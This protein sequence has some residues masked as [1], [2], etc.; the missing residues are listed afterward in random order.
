MFK[1][2]LVDDEAMARTGL[3]HFFDWDSSGFKIV[4]EASNGQ[5]AL[6]WIEDQEVDILIT[7]ISMP[8][9]DGL[10]LTRWTRKVSPQTKIILLSSYND[11]EFAREG[12]RLGASDY[13]LKPTLE[14]ENLSQALEKVTR[15]V[16]EEREKNGILEFRSKRLSEE[17]TLLK[18]LAGESAADENIVTLSEVCRVVV[19]S[20]DSKQQMKKDGIY[21]EIIMEEAQNIFY[22]MFKQGVAVRGAFDQI[23]LLLPLDENNK[24]ISLLEKFKHGL[25]ELGVSF[26]LG[27]SMPLSQPVHVPEA[28]TQAV[29]A[30]ER[31]FFQELGAIYYY[32][33]V[34]ELRTMQSAVYFKT[35][36][37]TLKRYVSDGFRHKAYDCLQEITGQWMYGQSTVREV[38]RQAQ[39]LLYLFHVLSPD[40]FQPVDRLCTLNMLETAEEVKEWIFGIFA[41]LWCE[42][43]NAQ[44]AEA[45]FGENRIH[46][47]V[48]AKAIEYIQAHYA[49]AISLRDVAK[50]VNMSKNYFSEVFKKVTG[51]NFVDYLIQLRLNRSKDLLQDSA[52]KV[53]EV[54]EM[55]G[56][57][58]VK[59]FSKLF[60]KVMQISPT[61]YREEYFRK[62]G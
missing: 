15:Q 39:E 55:S 3:R 49:E 24:F 9:M 7:D 19:C 46:Q 60:K 45:C 36:K 32:S 61:D 26:T 21:M 37:D 33:P 25:Q 59:Y 56:F 35:L 42:K 53:Y 48:V 54:A 62:N 41:E 27:V 12:I 44:Q 14:N 51:Q 8:V 31:G 4:G 30:V 43:K 28:Y 47:R 20:L 11:F 23:V 1:V 40:T 10:E 38:M 17:R 13:L 16:I 52:L 2:L 50:T 58:D 5:K 34:L 22:R 18:W 6:R 29:Q 57:S